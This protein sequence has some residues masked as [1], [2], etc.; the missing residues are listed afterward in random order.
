[1]GSRRG[2]TLFELVTV[3]AVV[4]IFAA[5]AVPGAAHVRSNVSGAEGAR[6]LALVLR[7]AQAESQSRFQR[8][9]VQVGTG[10]R[11]TVTGA[12]AGLLMGGELGTAVESTYPGGELEFSERG[13]AAL[14]GSAIPRAGH[15]SL[16]DGASSSVVTIQLSGFV[17]CA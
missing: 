10:G 1:M 15:F 4:G 14:P 5:V 16:G 8:V 7:A 3:M 9:R 2:S 12:D 13:W 6:R 11:Y 17:R